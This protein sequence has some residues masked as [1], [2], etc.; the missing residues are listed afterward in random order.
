MVLKY[1]KELK[2]I[3]EI[4]LVEQGR[5]HKRLRPASKGDICFHWWE[6]KNKERKAHQRTVATE[7]EFCLAN[8]GGRGIR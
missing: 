8:L 2:E 1:H 7:K 3:V 6:T 4:V 5:K